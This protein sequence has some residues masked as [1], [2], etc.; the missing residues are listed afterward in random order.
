MVKVALYQLYASSLALE[1][2]RSG[3]NSCNWIL[4]AVLGAPRL[5]TR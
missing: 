1:P 3:F 2:S 4:G 5:E